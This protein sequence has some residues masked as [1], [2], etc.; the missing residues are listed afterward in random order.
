MRFIIRSTALLAGRSCKVLAMACKQS[1]AQSFMSGDSR[2][3]QIEGP[4]V[5]LGSIQMRKLSLPELGI[6]GNLDA[7]PG[8]RVG[9]PFLGSWHS[10]V[11]SGGGFVEIHADEVPQLH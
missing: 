2:P 7:E 9:P 11:E 3:L 4:I 1:R 10:D 6:A 5:T 8:A